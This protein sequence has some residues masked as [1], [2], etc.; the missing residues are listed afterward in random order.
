MRVEQAPVVTRRVA[1]LGQSGSGRQG[2]P[3]PH[4]GHRQNGF[5]GVPTISIGTRHSVQFG[6]DQSSFMRGSVGEGSR[7]GEAAGMSFS[8]KSGGPAEGI[9]GALGRWLWEV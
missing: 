4:S 9:R 8:P 3:I 7:H 1:E 2:P 6:I 5:L